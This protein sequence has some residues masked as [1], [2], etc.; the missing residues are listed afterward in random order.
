M[1][2]WKDSQKMVKCIW[3][4]LYYVGKTLKKSKKNLKCR[5][6]WNDGA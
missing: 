5:Q 2:E 3:Q 4:E 6:R 1:V